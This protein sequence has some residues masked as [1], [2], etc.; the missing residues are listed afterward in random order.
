MTFTH[1]EDMHPR[2]AELME[3][4]RGVL[5]LSRMA[6]SNRTPAQHRQVITMALPCITGNVDVMFHGDLIQAVFKQE[7][8]NAN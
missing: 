3:L 1:P 4:I 6:D 2:I 5:D 7:G 8:I